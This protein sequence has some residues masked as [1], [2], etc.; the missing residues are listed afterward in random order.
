MTFRALPENLHALGDVALRHFGRE[1][2]IANGRFKIEEEISSDIGYRPTFHAVKADHSL[3]GVEISEE[4]LPAR[5]QTL[6]LGCK[7]NIVPLK[8][9]IV[10]PYGAVDAV[11]PTDV[12]FMKENGI[13]LAELGLDGRFRQLAGPPLAL[14]LTG[15]RSIKYSDYPARYREELR[16]AY[17]TF[18]GGNPSKGCSIIYDEIES[19]TRRVLKKAASRPNC[20][21]RAV[22]FNP[23]TESWSNI[24]SFLRTNFDRSASGCPNF[25]DT[26][27]SRLQGLTEYRNESGHKPKSQKKL[28]E[29]DR[30]LRTRFE[31]A[32]D[33][34]Q[35]L[36][37]ATRQLRP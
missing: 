9:W 5:I 3:V 29:R 1:Y 12:H 25:S 2:G 34:L 8:L 16:Q 15:L 22:G 24:L 7:N 19:L 14:S 32:L 4:P 10:I 30:R 18:V 26:L 31:A 23:D 21:R 37:H 20:L 13:G 17:D 6:V 36:I 35:A 27:L 33:E 11:R 28:I